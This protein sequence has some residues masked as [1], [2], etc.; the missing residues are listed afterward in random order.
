MVLLFKVP[1]SS[2][3]PHIL[4]IMPGII[5]I[6]HFA[7]VD[8]VQLYGSRATRNSYI[9][10]KRFPYFAEKVCREVQETGTL[11]AIL[12]MYSDLEDDAHR[13]RLCSGDLF[14]LIY[15][16]K[17]KRYAHILGPIFLRKVQSDWD[18]SIPTYDGRLF[19]SEIEET[20][21]II[22]IHAT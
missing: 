1:L 2:K 14:R 19:W 3:T 7:V 21:S 4:T 5:A 6:A 13:E 17:Y 9:S 20:G 22:E 11:D 12:K 10:R 8:S 15:L 16:P 18:I